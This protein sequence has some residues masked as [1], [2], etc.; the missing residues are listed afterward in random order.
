MNEIDFCSEDAGEC[1]SESAELTFNCSSSFLIFSSN[2]FSNCLTS[3]YSEVISNSL[4]EQP[5]FNSNNV[6][7]SIPLII[8]LFELKKRVT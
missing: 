6:N 4:F 7:K 1:N 5:E 3:S 8:L 2:T